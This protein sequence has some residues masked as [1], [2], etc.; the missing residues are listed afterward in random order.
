MRNQLGKGDWCYTLEVI[1]EWVVSLIH[2]GA[3]KN[4]VGS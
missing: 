4:T 1:E 3:H 2:G